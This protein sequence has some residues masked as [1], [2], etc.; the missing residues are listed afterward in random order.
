MN[1]NIKI[2][3]IQAIYNPDTKKYEKAF[4][5]I[6]GKTE[7]LTDNI[8]IMNFLKSLKVQEGKSLNEIGTNKLEVIRSTNPVVK[9]KEEAWANAARIVNS[10]VNK[11]SP[12]E[13]KNAKD[14]PKK[15]SKLKKAL[16]TGGI[17]AGVALAVT[18]CGLADKIANVFNKNKNAKSISE[19]DVKELNIQLTD[20]DILAKDFDFYADNYDYSIQ[21]EVAFTAN[22]FLEQ[23]NTNIKNMGL[24]TEDGKDITGLF[25]EEEAWVY[26]IT[27][28]N[29]R[30]DQILEIYNDS[31]F[32]YA[33]FEDTKQMMITKMMQYQ[34]LVSFGKLEQLD[35][36]QE[37]MTPHDDFV[38]SVF[39]NIATHIEEI[40]KNIDNK[41]VAKEKIKDLHDYLKEIA[42]SGNLSQN[43]QDMLQIMYSPAYFSGVLTE[44]SYGKL[45]YFTEEFGEDLVGKGLCTT[46]S[47]EDTKENEQEVQ[48]QHDSAWADAAENLNDAQEMNN[49]DYAESL[50]NKNSY[51]Y[52]MNEA[53]QT[54]ANEASRE[55]K[56]LY[57]SIT[58]ENIYDVHNK[59]EELV[60]DYLVTERGLEL[61]TNEFTQASNNIITDGQ[62][63]IL[64][65]ETILSLIS[66]NALVK[67]YTAD[68]EGYTFE[69]LQYQLSLAINNEISQAMLK[70][71]GSQGLSNG[72]GSTALPKDVQKQISL[73]REEAVARFGES[74]VQA[75]EKAAFD[76]EASENEA[77][78][79]A[80]DVK[81]KAQENLDKGNYD[82]FIND[83]GKNDPAN[84]DKY[85]E[86]AKEAV[87][88]KKETEKIEKEEGPS[89]K[90]N[91]DK[92][93]EDMVNK[94]DGFV[95]VEKGEKP[96][97]DVYEGDPGKIEWSDGETLGNNAD[98]TVTENVADPTASIEQ[99]TPK[100]EAPKEETKEPEQ[101]TNSGSVS[102]GDVNY[103]IPED[104]FEPVSEVKLMNAAPSTPEPVQ[105][106]AVETPE[107]NTNTG[108]VSGGEVV[109]D[110]PE[111]MFEPV[112]EDDY[113]ALVQAIDEHVEA[114]ANYPDDA[115]EDI[116]YQKTM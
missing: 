76:N 6:N 75:A 15:S 107:E 57:A 66:D 79:K 39:D 86:N 42:D 105:Q 3:K 96:E 21:Q 23:A 82:Q 40:G 102:G 55:D 101:N 54:L 58:V 32:D 31:K 48:S 109:Y 61:G 18:S 28:N 13:N 69:E 44:S 41:T 91:I 1:E 63:R 78:K 17:L 53:R 113:A 92:D 49:K 100:Q 51:I 35:F 19:E 88:N 36:T 20:K 70:I 87:E 111:D 24:K 59:A 4:V 110:V 38:K 34:M 22:A 74:A 47:D 112:A 37:F 103:D 5:T 30:V 60:K 25:T 81:D 85:E 94:G 52:W 43:V 99:E 97:G 116:S 11:T 68:I 104:M 114:L 14:M 7:V 80:E 27:I 72:G 89:G 65:V 45:T 64:A 26:A 83:A 93:L 108:S 29:L 2:E 67:G 106:A 33:N 10:K 77:K 95:E 46:K 8:Q 84:K 50:N 62:D 98:K 71:K 9:D 115:E 16:L 12:Y 56:H 90:E 73:S